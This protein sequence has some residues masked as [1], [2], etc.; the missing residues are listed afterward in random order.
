MERIAL[1]SDI[2]GNVPALEATLE[3]IA[4]R[5][6]ARI[7]CLGDLVGRGPHGDV[8]V[9]QVRARCE[10]VVRGNWDDAIG[11]LRVDHP[12]VLWHQARLGPERMAYLGNLPL[13]W[14][15][16]LSGKRIRLLHASPQDL[17]DRVFED[18]PRERLLAMFENTELTGDGPLPEVVVYGDI[19]AA[20]VQQFRPRLLVN[21]GSVGNPLDHQV[22]ATYVIIEGVP[23]MQPGPFSVTIAR[24]PYDV[25][26]AVREATAAAVPDWDVRVA[27]LRTGRFQEDA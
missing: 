20:F 10:G 24:V 26:R 15:I 8:V 21:T 18:S 27:E 6:I 16:D 7:F 23:G 9:D 11:L 13:S 12:V 14:E 4:R 1:I 5:G 22:D 2:H 17:H 25:E 19:H 3:D